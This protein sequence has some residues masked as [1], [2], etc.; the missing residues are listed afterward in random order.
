M[1]DGEEDTAGEA[2]DRMAAET[3]ERHAEPI[4]DAMELEDN[5][6]R[7]VDN[8]DQRLDDSSMRRKLGDLTR[9]YESLESRHRDLRDVGVAEAERNFDKLRKQ[10]DDNAAGMF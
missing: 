6:Y 10:A 3:V 5:S 9:K 1:R 7:G 2:E 8:E 4:A